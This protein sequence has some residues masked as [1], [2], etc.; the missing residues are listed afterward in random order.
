MPP[1]KGRSSCGPLPR[2]RQPKR[3]CAAAVEG[4]RA[5]ESLAVSVRRASCKRPISDR[6]TLDSGRMVIALPYTHRCATVTVRGGQRRALQGRAR[7]IFPG[8]CHQGP[9]TSVLYPPGPFV[10]RAP[11][12]RI[13]VS[14]ASASGDVV[15]HYGW[16][17]GCKLVTVALLAP[18]F[19]GRAPDGCSRD[20]AD[21]ARARPVLP[22]RTDR[23]AGPAPSP[24]I[25]TAAATLLEARPDRGPRGAERDGVS[26]CRGLTNH[27][28]RRYDYRGP[29]A[30]PSFP[31]R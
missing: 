14:Q 30:R 24:T 1:P 29:R 22:P 25:E 31:R 19:Q 9:R 11:A 10:L 17:Y 12:L 13:L 26:T 2:G 18:A 21:G 5:T 4:P 23:A 6:R 27:P 20:P 8:P 15:R 28:Q 16:S 7:R 3:T